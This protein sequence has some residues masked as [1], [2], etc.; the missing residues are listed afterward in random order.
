MYA[1]EIAGLIRHLVT[2]A[3]SV[4]VTHGYLN[5]D[6]LAEVSGSIAVIIAVAWSI[7]SKVRSK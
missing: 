3:G 5:S 2:I 7:I 1:S 4:A 6:Q